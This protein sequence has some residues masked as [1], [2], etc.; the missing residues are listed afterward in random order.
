MTG[1]SY[2]PAELDA[3]RRLFDQQLM[4]VAGV[5]FAMDP[6]YKTPVKAAQD[7][8]IIRNELLLLLA[9]E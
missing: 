2:T 3:L 7:A 4:T 9:C 1:A 6:D 8:I 5:M